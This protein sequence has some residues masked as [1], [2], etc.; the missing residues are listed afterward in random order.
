[1]DAREFGWC[2]N[3]SLGLG[4]EDRERIQIAT[5]PDPAQSFRLYKRR[6]APHE[7]VNHDATLCRKSS[8]Y[9]SDEL[10]GEAGG[11]TIESVGETAHRLVAVRGGDDVG[12]DDLAKNLELPRVSCNLTL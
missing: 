9:C 10:R 11:V 8:D 3:G 2:E 6:A 12:K 4:K 7:R 5:D 1:M